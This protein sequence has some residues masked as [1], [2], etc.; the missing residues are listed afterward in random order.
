MNRKKLK[1]EIAKIIFNFDGGIH[2]DE[3]KKITGK[4]KLGWGCFKSYR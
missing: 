1:E 4:E 2:P 3:F